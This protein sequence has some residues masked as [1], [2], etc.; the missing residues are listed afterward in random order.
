MTRGTPTLWCY[1]IYFD[2]RGLQIPV[3]AATRTADV[4]ADGVKRAADEAGPRRVVDVDEGRLPLPKLKCHL[5]LAAPCRFGEH[6]CWTCLPTTSGQRAFRTVNYTNGPQTD[7]QS[8]AF[9]K[10]NTIRRRQAAHK[11][12]QRLFENRCSWKK[13]DV[14]LVLQPVSSSPVRFQARPLTAL[15]P[16]DPPATP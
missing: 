3:G 1:F 12:E 9:F 6:V 15:L 10:T 8:A 14:V 2:R 11:A 7:S 5:P 4:V 16:P 13:I